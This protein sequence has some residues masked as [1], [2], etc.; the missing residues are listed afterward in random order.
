MTRATLPTRRM[1][2]TTLAKW[3]GHSFTVTIGFDDQ[4]RPMEAFADHAKGDMAAM[5]AD[6][7]VVISLALQHGI[8]TTDL[9]KSL[10]TVPDWVNGKQVD[11]PASPIGAIVG[12]LREMTP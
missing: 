5:L 2:A 1:N 4:G 7:C 8:T 9:T 11:A 12:I 10:G 6:A 3:S